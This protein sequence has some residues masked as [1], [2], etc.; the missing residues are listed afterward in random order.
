MASRTAHT[1]KATTNTHNEVLAGC[2]GDDEVFMQPTSV[3]VPFEIA[4]RV[5]ES[6]AIR[7]SRA[8]DELTRVS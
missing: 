7:D 1:E 8:N 5:R 6:A 4:A 2:F 3:H